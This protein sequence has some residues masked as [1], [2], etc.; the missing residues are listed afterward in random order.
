MNASLLLTLPPVLVILLKWT[1][2]LVLGWT[3][4]WLLRH[5][6]ARWRLILWRSLLCFGLV[7]PLAHSVPIH[8][9]RIPVESTPD[10]FADL[11]GA[12]APVA[13]GGAVQPAE[14]PRTTLDAGGT[15]R[16]VSSPPTKS[17]P[18][19]GS[20]KAFLVMIWALGC[21][22]GAVRLVVLHV[23][24]FRLR[25]K[26]RVSNPAL[27][28]LA[29]EIREQLSVRRTIEIRISD[30]V[31]SPFVCGLWKPVIMLP[32]KL[33]RELS[34]SEASALL[35]HEIAHVRQR[36]LVWCIGW[37][38][39][40]ALWWFHPL[41]WRIPAVHNLACEQEADRIASG[42]LEDRGSYAQ[43]LARMALRVLALP[44]VE[45]ALTVNGTSQI[46]QRLKHLGREGVRAW[47]WKYSV[48]GFGL[49]GMFFLTIAGCEFS[50]ANSEMSVGG[51]YKKVLIV[52]QDEDGK[53]IEGATIDPHG[54]R[55][56]QVHEA[57][58]YNWHSWE[59]N[60]KKVIT[61]NGGKAYLRYPVVA[62]PEEKELTGKLIFWVSHPDFATVGVQSYAVDGTE[63]PIRLARGI[64][65][66]ISGYFGSDH[67]P[68][69]EITPNLGGDEVVLDDWQK[70]DRVL[71][72]RKLSR[73][74]HF[75]QLMGRLPS[76]EIVYSD[77]LAF[78]AEK[79]KKY[80]F[81][82]EMKAGIRLEGRLDDHVPRPVNHGRVI[83]AVRPKE[84]PA[85]LN[86]GESERLN[87]Q[88]GYF[89]PWRSYRPIT[90][91]G[92]F[93]FESVPSGEVDVVVQGD[94]FVSKNGG[95]IQLSPEHRLRIG[96]PQSFPL[97]APLTRIEVTT[98][99]GAT[100]ELTART[101]SGEPIKG[102]RH[103]TVSQ[104]VAN[105]RNLRRPDEGLQRGTI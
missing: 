105:E 20:W 62:V 3:V 16:N 23:Q 40:K 49:M 101:K 34:S 50:K 100:L 52:V 99:P 92:S 31:T 24:L 2:L 95:E 22:C 89:R 85:Y 57:D 56:K 58:A 38:W 87:K 82:V 12:A 17:S 32:E 54:F 72:L 84:F 7:L 67:Q 33:A 75:L 78:T 80:E 8:L 70:K 71:T 48:A 102:C 27:Q 90:A 73:G 14:T 103:Y 1:A 46:A 66:S 51:P 9:L 83:I 28:K 4:H 65:L 18:E 19:A 30:S 53:P 88:Y 97:I 35:S 42:Q 63:K 61:D 55:I 86:F 41:V 21:A 93:V 11:S 25:K 64:Q 104:R 15:S 47:N 68:V 59:K 36:D 44:N 81:A 98:E 45:T 94:G 69:R 6:H 60:P 91:D 10:S 39:M 79:G 43:L 5:R 13:K 37:R 26:A 74:P 77:G 96:V 29:E 76:G